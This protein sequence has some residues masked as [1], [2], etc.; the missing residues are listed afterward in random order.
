MISNPRFNKGLPLNLASSN[1]KFQ[2]INR[3]SIKQLNRGFSDDFRE[4][5]S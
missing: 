3:R 4:S 1:S 5:K 2:R